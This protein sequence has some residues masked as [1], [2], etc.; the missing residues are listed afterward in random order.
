M[1]IKIFF[2]NVCVFIEREKKYVQVKNTEKQMGE[3]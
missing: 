2:I 1:L 3:N